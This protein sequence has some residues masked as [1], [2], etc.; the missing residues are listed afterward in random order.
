M[1]AAFRALTARV[2]AVAPDA[3][4]DGVLVAPELSGGVETVLGLTH[5]E[6]FGPVVMVGLGGVFAEVLADVAF[7]APPSGGPRP[8]RWSTG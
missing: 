4:M 8:E 1:A 6:V 5:D 3:R 7:R 2:A